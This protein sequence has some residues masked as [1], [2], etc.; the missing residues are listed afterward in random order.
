MSV[1]EQPNQQQAQHWNEVAGPTWVEMQ[2]VTDRMLAP[3][4]ARLTQRAF[5][6]VGQ[7]VLDV[8]CG[9]G[10]TTLAMA[11]R[12]GPDGLCLG[13]DIS[14]PLV[15]AA[16]ARAQAEALPAA[17]FIEADAQTHRFDPGLFDAVISRFGVM[18]FDDPV[19]A[20]ANLAHATAPGGKLT[21][22]AWR[23]PMENPFFVTAALALAPFA[24]PPT[25]TAPDAPGQFAFADEARVRGILEAAG[26]T[27][28]AF[29]RVDEICPMQRADLTTY[30]TRMGP[31]AVALR[32]A[33][34]ATRAQAIAAL[35]TAFA[36]Y[37]EGD[38][39]RVPAACWEVTALKA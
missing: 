6:G 3:F 13:V 4:E 2:D 26:W 35:E 1:S 30:I 25:P 18:F 23:S 24:P 21:F 37:I 36:P 12:L 9:A 33:D 38:S 22:M 15:A 17:A 8:G 16:K 29:D 32:D 39:V 10:A 28:I 7:S 11:R 20:F 31:A 19:A 14:A 34:T 27:S 5:P